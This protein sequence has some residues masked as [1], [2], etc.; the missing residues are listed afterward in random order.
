MPITIRAYMDNSDG[1]EVAFICDDIWSLPEQFSELERWVQTKAVA[2]PDGEY[3]V[4]VG[5]SPRDGAAGGGAT[6]S[7]KV[8]AIMA[9]KGLSLELSE[10]PPFEG[11]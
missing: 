4:D 11:E 2:L 3:V 10:Y 8:L 7:A 6:L 1:R 9:S 5:F